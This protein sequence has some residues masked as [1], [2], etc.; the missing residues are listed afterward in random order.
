MS[1]HAGNLPFIILEDIQKQKAIK[2]AC[3]YFQKAT[4]LIERVETT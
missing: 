1:Y 4:F 2:I 3:I